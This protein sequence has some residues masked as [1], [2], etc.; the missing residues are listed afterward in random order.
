MLNKGQ[1]ILAGSFFAVIF[2]GSLAFWL[3][4]DG[5]T[6]LDA[7]YM[8][9][10]SVTTVGYGEVQTLSSAGR[11]VAMAVLF[12][13]LG[14]FGFVIS[15][16]TSFAV[17]GAL[18]GVVQRRRTAKLANKLSRHSVY[19]G[20]GDRGYAPAAGNL[21][22]VV[23]EPN[24]H[25]TSAIAA[26]QNK[27][28]VLHAD[29]HDAEFLKMVGASRAREIIVVVG[30]DSQNLAVARAIRERLG[31]KAQPRVIA[32]VEDYVTRDCFADALHQ[33]G[34]ELFGFGE[35]SLLDLAQTMALNWVERWR[36][37]P[38][39]PI[40][41]L[42]QVEG[43][44]LQE[45]IRVFAMVLQFGGLQKLHIDV[46]GVTVAF[47]KG[48]EA[49]FPEYQRCA[50]INWYAEEF[51]GFGESDSAPDLAFF[52]APSVTRT[53]E[54]AL[55]CLRGAS[56][57][58][59]GQVYGCYWQKEE[60]DNIIRN[61]PTINQLFKLF[62]LYDLLAQKDGLVSHSMDDQGRSLHEAYRSNA[63]HTIVT[64][65]DLSEFHR[66]SNR[67]AALQQVIYRSAWQKCNDETK[68]IEWL[69][70]LAQCEHLRWM[71]FHLLCGYRLDRQGL[72]RDQ[73]QRLKVHP[74]LVPF[75]E[76]SEKEREKDR[77][78]IRNAIK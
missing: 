59:S 45:V 30:S 62:S 49:R 40:K 53:S 27:H 22:S 24:A 55:R 32:A 72:P 11:V 20:F 51:I 25:N 8:T 64:W 1:W 23:V 47:C 29:A 42:L 54:L 39:A 2:G 78:N 71:S 74:D 67:L 70:Y 19:Y 56:A 28:L 50:E 63:E 35:Q 14:I 7:F 4:E 68:K 38:G 44:L 60:S 57:M 77:V 48:F 5:W 9:I 15:Q 12:S 75:V 21:N 41:I 43:A 3:V 65:R 37:L 33:E 17:G 16:I 46:Y 76:L 52:A 10:I 26:K 6:W 18:E 69:E 73:W 58:E 13:G 66:N 61:L 31:S 36:D 34:I